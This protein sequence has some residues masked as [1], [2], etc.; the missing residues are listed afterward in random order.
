MKKFFYPESIAI[1]GASSDEIRMTNNILTNLMEVGYQGEIFPVGQ[2]G[3]E[4]FGYRIYRSLQEIQKDIDL[5]VIMVPAVTVPDL[6]RDAGKAG[7]D[8]AVLITAGF[9]ELGGNGTYPWR[10]A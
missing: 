4:I 8:R 3:K 2:K 1:A 9:N 5:L 10:Q 6:L 7:V